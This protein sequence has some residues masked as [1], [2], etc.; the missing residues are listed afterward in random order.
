[1]NDMRDSENPSA[2]APSGGD[3]AR[4]AGA[5]LITG[6]TGG[7]GREFARRFA[8]EGRP[9]VLAARSGASL[10]SLAGEL[11]SRFGVAVDCVA[12]DLSEPLAAQRLFDEAGRLGIEVDILVNNAGLAYDA[13]F[14]GS[15]PA[16]QRALVQVDVAAPMELALLFGGLMAKRGRGGILNVASVASFMPGPGMA[17]YYASKAFVRS[18]SE[19]LRVEL[20]GSG[21]H[22]CALCPGPVRTPFWDTAGAGHTLLAHMAVGP[23]R[24]VDAGMRSLRRNKAVC[25]PGVLWKATVFLTRFVP[26]GLVARIAAVLQRPA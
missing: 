12:C 1:M 14:M 16:R 13:P 4:G 19:A 23:G 24:I 9:L 20:G 2:V 21:V 5:V 3:V 22:V 25:V 8:A 11:R 18:L 15:D 7:L 26:R 10:D 17:T 6:A